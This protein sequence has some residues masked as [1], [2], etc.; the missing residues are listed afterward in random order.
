MPLI[1]LSE[2]QRIFSFRRKL[3]LEERA[4]EKSRK[5]IFEKYS[6]FYRFAPLNKSCAGQTFSETY[7][8][9]PGIIFENKCPLE[10]ELFFVITCVI[11]SFLKYIRFLHPYKLIKIN[12]S[13]KLF[14]C[15][16]THNPL[17]DFVRYICHY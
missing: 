16:A 9:K 6:S 7:V 4:L 12:P 11:T 15:I 14:F 8:L 5:R 2:T 3:L 10:Q 1:I 13:K 17:S